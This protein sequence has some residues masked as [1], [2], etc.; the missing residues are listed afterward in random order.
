MSRWHKDACPGSVAAARHYPN[1]SSYEAEEGTAAHELAETCLKVGLNAAD[2]LDH[3]F[4]GIKVD[5]EM[6]E[7]VQGFLDYVRNIVRAHSDGELFVEQ[8]FHLDTIHPAI[9]GMIDVLVVGGNDIY[10]ID[11]KYG[12]V[13]VL[14][15]NNQQLNYYSLYAAE[16]FIQPNIFQVIYQPRV[17]RDNPALMHATTAE[18]I[19]T[20]TTTELIPSIDL[21]LSDNAPRR[22][23]THCRYCPAKLDCPE[24][25]RE[26]QYMVPPFPQTNEQLA[27]VLDMEKPIEQMVE[28]AKKRGAEKLMLGETIPGYK[29]VRSYGKSAIVDQDACAKELLAAG[30]ASGDIYENK[31]KGITALKKIKLAEQIVQKYT[32][33]KENGIVPAPMSSTKPA[34]AIPTQVFRN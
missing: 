14:A 9:H 6:V 11:F 18:S 8:Q 26:L 29:P 5:G 4:N 23:G 3:E 15:E 24:L 28:D 32:N 21:A 19:Y 10:V 27:F 17:Y 31:L 12:R 1:L 33:R 34:V 2:Y 13:P 20:W 7:H 22:P 25:Q 30:V 16:T